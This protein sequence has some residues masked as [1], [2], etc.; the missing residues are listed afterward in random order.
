LLEKN[1]PDAAIEFRDVTYTTAQGR[2][3][4]DR[5]TTSVPTGTT[6]AILGRSGCGKTTLLR[7]LA[8]IDR[9][10]GGE[11]SVP[12]R[13]AVVFQDARLF[14]WKRAWENVM[15]GLARGKSA[16]KVA[17][18]ALEEVGLGHRVDAWPGELSGG[19]AQR[20]SL[21]RALVREP[22]LLLLDEPFAA[23]DALTRLKMHALVTELHRRHQPATLMVTHDVEEAIVLGDRVCV[24][25]GG[26]ILRDVRIE[27]SRPRDRTSS[28]FTE[29]RRSLL[30]YLGVDE[31]E[32]VTR[33][34]QADRQPGGDQA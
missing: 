12:A 17:M 4:L 6:V 10:N 34:E 13:I 24:M 25:E 1:M 3:L 31:T 15:V 18:P 27:L 5:I 23:I 11:L 14:P 32:W 21:A 20:L 19:Q 28:E 8:G 7:T 30:G 2:V 16:R 26:Q 33:H 9:L 29:L 22:E